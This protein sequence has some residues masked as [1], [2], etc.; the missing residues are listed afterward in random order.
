MSRGFD[1]KLGVDAYVVVVGNDDDMEMNY[2]RQAAGRGCR[3]MGQ[4]HAAIFVY[5]AQAITGN[6]KM[7]VESRTSTNLW[8][9]HAVMLKVYENI[10]MIAHQYQEALYDWWFK[11][12][13]ML[14]SH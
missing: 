6:P 2:V 11:G 7:V 10:D 5:A 13:W 3:S 1:L 14:D 4:A 12:H 9:G 8:T